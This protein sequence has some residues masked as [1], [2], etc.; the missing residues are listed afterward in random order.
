MLCLTVLALYLDVRSAVDS[1]GEPGRLIVEVRQ[2][3]EPVVFDVYEKGVWFWPTPST[4]RIALLRVSDWVDGTVLRE[5]EASSK[6]RHVVVTYGE[7]PKGFSQT[8]PAAGVAPALRPGGWYGVTVRGD[9]GTAVATFNPRFGVAPS[10]TPEER[11]MVTES[12]RT[13][14]QYHR[15]ERPRR[16]TDNSPTTAAISAR[17]LAS[18]DPLSAWRAICDLTDHGTR[19]AGPFAGGLASG[20]GRL[21]CRGRRAASKSLQTWAPCD[22]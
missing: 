6:P 16:W 19:T 11:A 13:Q 10:A 22:P 4:P 14:R 21:L 9:Y 17:S 18:R 2:R 5:I 7:P 3:S 20:L 1:A 12:H 8:I 15:S